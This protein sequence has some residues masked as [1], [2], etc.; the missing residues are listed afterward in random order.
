VLFWT[1][2]IVYPLTQ[3]P[4]A[5]RLMILL[6]PMSPFVVAYQRIFYEGAWPDPL[7][8]IIGAAY[9]VTALTLGTLW[10]M[11]VEDRLVEQL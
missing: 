2:P 1:T 8:W 6:S 3:V 9:A 10:L 4:E 7:L 11:S 5:A